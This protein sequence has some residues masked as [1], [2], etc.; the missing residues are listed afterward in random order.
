MPLIHIGLSH[1]HTPF[2]FLSRIA[3]PAATAD[4]FLRTLTQDS[5]ID[6]AVGLHTCNRTEFTL[7]AED[8]TEAARHLLACLARERGVPASELEEHARILCEEE[9][10]R[11][12]FSVASGIES[13]VVGEPEILGQVRTALDTA[14]IAGTAGPIVSSLYTRALQAGRRA[15]SET[16][17]GRGKVSIASVAAD[18]MQERMPD[19]AARTVLV[20]GT[21]DMGRTVAS[22]LAERGVETL[23]LTNRSGDKARTAAEAMGCL[24]IP[25]EEMIQTLRR[26]DI[27]ICATGAPHAII[28]REMAEGAGPC[29]YFD[30]SV[31]PNVA[32]DVRRVAG[33]TVLTIADLDEIAGQ[34]AERR[35]GE[36]HAVEALLEDEIARFQQWVNGRPAEELVAELR[37]DVER[38]RRGHLDRYG[39]DFDPGYREKLDVFT[40]S[41]LSAVLHRLTMNLGSVE[42]DAEALQERIEFAKRLFAVEIGAERRTGP[43]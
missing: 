23:L 41:L 6:E 40:R 43:E 36:V 15:R 34:N 28:T 39:K 10:V 21:G 7:V 27:V 26:A 12:L 42:H 24:A 16:G 17:I 1:R 22:V 37:R 14:K 8:T 33:A 9:A 5:P 38:I 30:L 29:L 18:L 35:S 3:L 25:M 4:H 2:E 32:P 19:L 11:H 13:L 20:I 31:P